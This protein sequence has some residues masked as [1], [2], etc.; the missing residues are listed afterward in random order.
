MILSSLERKHRE[1]DEW[2]GRM[3]RKEAYDF[4]VV[5]KNLIILQNF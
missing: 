4:P 3:V 5:Y 1:K 2:E